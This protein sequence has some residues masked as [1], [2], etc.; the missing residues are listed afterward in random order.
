MPVAKA[1]PG[2][3]APAFESRITDAE[4][5]RLQRSRRVN[6][7]AYLSI[8]AGFFGYALWAFVFAP[9]LAEAFDRFLALQIVAGFAALAVW[10]SGGAL[11]SRS[12]WRKLSRLPVLCSSLSAALTLLLLVGAG[13]PD[14]RR[15]QPASADAE[16]SAQGNGTVTVLVSL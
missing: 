5:R 8:W 11:R 16:R 13:I 12:F 6:L 1:V 10:L 14:D 9:T 15:P 3:M 2:A 4:M 7:A